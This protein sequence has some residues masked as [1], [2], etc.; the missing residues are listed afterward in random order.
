MTGWRIG[1]MVLP[2]TLVRAG[3]ADPAEP[4]HLAAGAVA[5]RRDRGLRARPPN[6]KSVKARYAANREL[7][8]R[9]L[10]EL[11]F[12]LAAPMDGAFYAFCDVSRPHQ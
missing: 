2:E 7:L 9:R 11:G 4:L 1:W 8:M 5:D 3:R 12:R 6:W 10:P